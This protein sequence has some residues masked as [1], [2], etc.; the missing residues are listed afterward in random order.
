M[1]MC[2]LC[3]DRVP[4]EILVV[5]NSL[6]ISEFE[7]TVSGGRIIVKQENSATKAFG[8]TT[9]KKY[10]IINLTIPKGVVK[11]AKLEASLG[12][13]PTAAET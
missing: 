12:G 3:D 2:R 5:G 4:A 13:M 6:A 8:L 11:Y 1:S 7:N 9:G 10:V